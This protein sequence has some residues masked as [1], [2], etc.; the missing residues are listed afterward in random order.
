VLGSHVAYDG[1]SAAA[2]A[3]SVAG[4]SPLATQQQSREELYDA[5]HVEAAPLWASQ[6]EPS[7]YGA[8]LKEFAP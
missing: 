8:F 5:A 2:A 1:Q 3:Q 7:W 4:S 6:P